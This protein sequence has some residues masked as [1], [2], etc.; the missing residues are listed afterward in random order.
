MVTEGG[1][2]TENGRTNSASSEG[3]EEPRE[4]GVVAD[5]D[6]ADAKGLNVEFTRSQTLLEMMEG[7]A[8]DR[9]SAGFESLAGLADGGG[10]RGDVEFVVSLPS[11]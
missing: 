6:K 1:I 11:S 5:V 4:L 2:D 10:G 7:K 8:V 9:G 3:E